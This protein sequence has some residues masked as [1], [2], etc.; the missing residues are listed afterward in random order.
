MFNMISYLSLK[1]YLLVV[2]RA[3]I[4]YILYQIS[5]THFNKC[6]LYFK[7]YG[8]TFQCSAFFRATIE[9]WVCGFSLP[10]LMHFNTSL[11]S[12]PSEH[13]K[14][15][16]KVFIIVMMLER[17]PSIWLMSSRCLVLQSPPASTIAVLFYYGQKTTE[18]LCL[19]PNAT[20][21]NVID[22]MAAIVNIFILTMTTIWQPICKKW[23]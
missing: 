12:V 9:L 19:F 16:L 5:S 7:C 4:L 2:C 17:C 8:S 1:L 23:C 20:V 18:P 10:S 14:L 13:Q 3:W 15:T 21:D 6:N 22:L 11:Y